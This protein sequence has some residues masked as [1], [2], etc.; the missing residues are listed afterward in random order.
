MLLAIDTS[1]GTS[2]A[3]VDGD[4]VVGFGLDRYPWGNWLARRIEPSIS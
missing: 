4:R 1:A 2:V 3:V